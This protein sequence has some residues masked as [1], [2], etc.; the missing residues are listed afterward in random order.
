[1][2]CSHTSAAACQE[3]EVEGVCVCLSKLGPLGRGS[4]G[5]GLSR[6]SLLLRNEVLETKAYNVVN[7]LPPD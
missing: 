2:N 6:L 4:E 1:M 3:V 5:V 7:I